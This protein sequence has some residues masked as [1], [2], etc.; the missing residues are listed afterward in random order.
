GASQARI[1][2]IQRLDNNE[3]A[4]FGW[5]AAA[6]MLKKGIVKRDC[7]MDLVYAPGGLVGDPTTPRPLV[8]VSGAG[9]LPTYTVSSDGQTTRVTK[10][11]FT[12]TGPSHE[13]SIDVDP[14]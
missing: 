10:F 4:V 12:F 1:T 3:L 6:N 11:K 14:S 13:A 7:T 8:T 2:G 5:D 9:G